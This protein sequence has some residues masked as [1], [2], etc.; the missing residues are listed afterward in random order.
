MHVLQVTSL[1]AIVATWLIGWRVGLRWAR[2]CGVDERASAWGLACVLPT[3]GLIFAVH[4][5]A[6]VSLIPGVGVYSPPPVAGLFVLLIGLARRLVARSFPADPGPWSSVRPAGERWDSRTSGSISGSSSLWATLGGWR[7]AVVI[8]AAMYAVFLVDAVTRYPTGSDGLHYHLPV[9]LQWMRNQSMDL[10]FG[11]TSHSYRNNGMIVAS[12][13]LFAKLEPL[14]TLIHL[15]KAALLALVIFGL[16]RAVGASG[17]ASVMAACISLSVPM[18]VFQSFSSYIDLYAAASWLSA[19]LA[20]TWAARTPRRDRRTGLLILSGLS[21]GV[22][23]GSKETYL[24]L[25]P[26]LGVVAVA[27]AWIPWRSGAGARRDSRTGGRGNSAHVRTPYRNGV[28]FL[29]AALACSAFWFCRGAVQAGNPIYPLGV[30]IGGKEVLPGLIA[31]NLYPSH[32]VAVKLRRWWAYPWLETKYTGTGY[33]YSVNN[34][35][36]A[37]YTTFVP[38]GFL[39]VLLRVCATGF[40]SVGNRFHTRAPHEVWQLILLVLAAAGPLVAMVFFREYVRY[41]LPLVLVPIPLTAVLLDRLRGRFERPVLA[42]ATCALAATAAIAA[43]KPAHAFAGRVKDGVWDRAAYYEVPALI[44]EFEPHTRIL[45]HDSYERGYSLSGRNLTNVVITP[46]QW[47]MLTKG[48][49]M[50]DRALQDHKIDYIYLRGP[51]PP[52]WPDDLCVEAVYDDSEQCRENGRWA[53]RMYRVVHP[54][55]PP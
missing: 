28:V 37:A 1:C 49:A 34:A 20:L 9:A 53:T 39:A 36:G 38:L 6:F 42:I 43:L 13:M 22:A 44:D 26:L 33:P 8:V 23:L 12:L 21:A 47:K 40:R 45:N 46:P 35:F 10:I 30:A 5:T 48:Q 18:V 51:V 31:G 52:T 15:P 4:L 17:R 2:G 55:S 16:A 54:E 7:I 14:L 50:S 19:L 29:L 25:T 11:L 41:V 3:A 24:L 32:P 27:I